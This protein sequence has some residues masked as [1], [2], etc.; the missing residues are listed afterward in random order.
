ME[1][2]SDAQAGPLAAYGETWAWFKEYGGEASARYFD[3]AFIDVEKRSRA[4]ASRAI[5]KRSVRIIVP[6]CGVV[7]GLPADLALAAYPP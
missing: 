6:M 4:E 5:D 1:T 7:H 2:K 3:P